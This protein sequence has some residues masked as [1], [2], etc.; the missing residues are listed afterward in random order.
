MIQINTD[1][2]KIFIGRFSTSLKIST[3]HFLTIHLPQILHY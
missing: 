1:T 3:P 2:L